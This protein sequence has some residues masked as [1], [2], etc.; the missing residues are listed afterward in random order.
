MKNNFPAATPIVATLLYGCGEQG[1]SASR[2]WTAEVYPDPGALSESRV[3]GEFPSHDA[4]VAAA[5]KAL[6]GNG[7]FNCSTI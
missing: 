4:C 5:M 7:V 1:G 6:G 2:P 3:L